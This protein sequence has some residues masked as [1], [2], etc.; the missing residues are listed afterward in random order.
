MSPSIDLN[1]DLGEEP[2][3]ETR[4][5]ALMRHISSCNIACG[6]HAGDAGS[7]T[8]M[9]RAA[10]DAGVAAGAHPLILIAH[11]SAGHRSICRLLT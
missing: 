2:Q 7:M 5:I 3:E 6:G 4:D 9:L 11:A 8:R 1:A 10:R